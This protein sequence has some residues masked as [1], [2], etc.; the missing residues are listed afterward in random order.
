MVKLQALFVSFVIA[1]A[2]VSPTGA[3]DQQR[4]LCEK[5]ATSVRLA[6]TVLKANYLTK[7]EELAAALMLPADSVHPTAGV[8]P[9]CRVEVVITP[10]SG[11]DIKAEVW[12]PDGSRWNQR[13]LSAGIGGAAGFIDR[14]QLVAG[15]AQGYAM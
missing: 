10:A 12:L 15:V 13:F 7:Q 9:M 2:A 4:M 11:A 14:P 6:D 1:F 8:L 5:L 3:T